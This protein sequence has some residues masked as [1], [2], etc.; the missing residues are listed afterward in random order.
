M[1]EY[2]F[3]LLKSRSSCYL[4]GSFCR[5]VE[6][7]APQQHVNFL[8]WLSPHLLHILIPLDLWTATGCEEVLQERHWALDHQH[9]IVRMDLLYN[10]LHQGPSAGSY[11]KHSRHRKRH[12]RRVA[13]IFCRW[14]Q[15]YLGF[16]HRS[17]TDS[18]GLRGAAAWI[19]IHHD[20]A[21]HC[22]IVWK[23]KRCRAT[24]R[25]EEGWHC[26]VYIHTQI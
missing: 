22:A 1:L 25:A 24:L 26:Q 11:L 3:C 14:T 21:R 6:P 8:P 16:S 4:W 15:F 12:H 18:W 10:V 9:A 2:L 19:L 20:Q 5:A 13:I 7:W 17:K 23:I